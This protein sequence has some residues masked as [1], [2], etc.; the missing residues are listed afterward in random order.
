[1]ILG[2]L[3]DQEN[4]DNFNKF[5]VVKVVLNMMVKRYE[6]DGKEDLLKAI[7]YFSKASSPKNNGKQQRI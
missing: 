2:L 1:M 3:K 5:I 4:Q 7:L 6:Y